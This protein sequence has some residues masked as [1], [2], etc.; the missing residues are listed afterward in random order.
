MPYELRQNMYIKRGYMFSHH[1]L[2][3]RHRQNARRATPNVRT[4][5]CRNVRHCRRSNPLAPSSQRKKEEKNFVIT[6]ALHM[7]AKQTR[8]NSHISQPEGVVDAIAH[9]AR[10]NIHIHTPS[11]PVQ[12]T[13]PDEYVFVYECEWRAAIRH[14]SVRRINIT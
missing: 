9:S 13:Y 2:H 12:Y 7:S 11:A 3:Q 10:I 5:V 1:R 14:L 6:T 4:T 8:R